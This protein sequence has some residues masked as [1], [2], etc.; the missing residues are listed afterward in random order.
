MRRVMSGVLVATLAAFLAP[1]PAVTAASLPSPSAPEVQ[2]GSQGA[3]PCGNVAGTATDAAKNPLPNHTVRIRNLQTGQI[4]S[5]STTASNGS[6]SFAGLNP[7]NYVVEVVT[8][9]GTTIVGTSSTVAV[10]AGQTVT[11]A[12]SASALAAAASAAAA[13]GLLGLSTT[14][15]VVGAVAVGGIVTAAI[16]ATNEDASPSR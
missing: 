4:T 2:C 3:P 14:T 13:G 12:V 9:N 5:T 11:V 16:V 10:V 6:F 1:A 7:G 15:I 8:A